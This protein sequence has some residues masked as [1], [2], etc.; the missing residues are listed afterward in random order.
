ME[1]I[2]KPISNQVQNLYT[3]WNVYVMENVHIQSSIPI[4]SPIDEAFWK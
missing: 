4:I 3:Q 1:N 2:E